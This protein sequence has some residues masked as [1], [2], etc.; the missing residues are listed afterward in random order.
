MQTQANRDSLLSEI[1]Q[2]KESHHP[3]RI[4]SKTLFN[5][6]TEIIIEHAEQEY[7]LRITRLNKLILTK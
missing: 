1:T 2:R 6:A 4:S 7:R 3:N 5:G